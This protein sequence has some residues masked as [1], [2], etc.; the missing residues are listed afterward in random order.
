MIDLQEL[1]DQGK[2]KVN[3]EFLLSNGGKVYFVGIARRAGMY[4]H[5]VFEGMLR[6][7]C[8]FYSSGRRSPMVDQQDYAIIKKVPKKK[9]VWANFYKD[10]TIIH[11]YRTFIFD[12]KEMADMSASDGRIACLEI[13]IEVENE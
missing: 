11:S 5:F 6:G 1:Y 10:E 8:T 9:K 12:T 13:E 7:V 4:T 3:D 2:L